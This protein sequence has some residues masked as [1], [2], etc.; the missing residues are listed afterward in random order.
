MGH[1][2]APPFLRSRIPAGIAV[3]CA[4]VLV[5][6][7]GGATGALL[8]QMGNATTPAPLAPAAPLGGG[9]QIASISAYV[10]YYSSYLPTGAMP[11]ATSTNYPSEVAAGGSIVFNWT[12]FTERSIFSLTYTPSY[13][14][15]VRNSS[16]DALNHALSFT[17]SRKI[18]PRWNFSFSAAGNLSSVQ[19]SLFAP[20]TLSNVASASSSFND[21]A[22]GLL[23]ANFANNP[24]LGVIL[25][26]SPLVESPLGNL[27]YGQ[28]M[29]TSS[30]RVSLGYSYSPRLSV[31]FSGGGSR[32]QHVSDPALGTGNSYVIP[33]TTSGTASVAISY[34]LS[35][36]T[37]IGGS[38]TTTRSDSLLQDSYITTSLATMGRTIGGRW[39]L[40]LHGGVGV[41][42]ALHQTV[43]V[44]PAKPV[45]A[46]GGGLTYKTLSHTFLG[47]YDRTVSDSYGL[48]ASTSST[49]TAAWHWRHP[50]SSWGLDSSFS[51]QQLQGNNA[52]ANTSGWSTT[53]GLTRAFGAHI[54]L[55]TQ[56]VHLSYSGGLLAAAYHYSQDAVRVSIGWTPRAAALR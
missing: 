50:G 54:T 9:L 21:L 14:G 10:N 47:S 46:V 41:T 32:T 49:A 8:A 18:A 48:G 31:I 20:S 28:R 27:L 11:S 1:K 51:W 35:P 30:A 37:Q 12:K 45:P 43:S 33:D 19:Q 40:Q 26:S 39:V 6:M 53:A 2:P 22:A 7:W 44:T 25:T 16:L 42:N 29:F 24:Q 15:Y 13:T 34:S 56:Y 38:V 36:F 5:L 52:L 23:S 17:A 4:T 3:R 55:T